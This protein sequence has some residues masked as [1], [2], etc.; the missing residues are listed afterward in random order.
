MASRQENWNTPKP[1]KRER[2]DTHPSPKELFNTAV[3]EATQETGSL[4]LLWHALKSE[5]FICSVKEQVASPS[6]DANKHFSGTVTVVSFPLTCINLIGHGSLQL[7][8]GKISCIQNVGPFRSKLLQH[9][10]CF[11]RDF[12]DY[13]RRSNI[14]PHLQRRQRLQDL[15]I[16]NLVRRHS[17][18]LLIKQPHKQPNLSNTKCPRKIRRSR[19]KPEN[20]NGKKENPG[21]MMLWF[22]PRT[23]Q[24]VGR[25][26]E[27]TARICGESEEKKRER[28]RVVMSRWNPW[29]SWSWAYLPQ[30]Y[31]AGLKKPTF[32]L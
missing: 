2:R 6:I 31:S 3:R 16:V 24:Q 29:F 14:I 17:G 28:A 18:S 27:R 15:M 22:Q 21:E 30:Q 4:I 19:F 20:I 23:P 12:R 25:E 13:G 1:R 10:V 32:P 5:H 9:N 8:Q 7:L 11:W 26:S